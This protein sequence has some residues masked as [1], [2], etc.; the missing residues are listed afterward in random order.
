M[1]TTSSWSHADR[2]RATYEALEQHFG[3]S[4]GLYYETAPHR[5]GDRFAYDWPYSQALAGVLDMLALFPD[6][7]DV[8]RRAATRLAAHEAFWDPQ[9]RPPAYASAVVP[10]LGPSG[11][12]F[13]DDNAWDGLNLIRYVRFSGDG[14]WLE[15]ARL[16]FE[17]IVSGWDRDRRHPC[18][19]GVFWVR[20]RW[21]RDRGTVCNAPA[22]ILALH[23]DELSAGSQPRLFDWAKRMYQWTNRHLIAPNGLYW[24]KVLP[25]GRIDEAHWSYNQ[26]TMIGASVRFYRLTGD[27]AYRK[28]AE[29]I[30]DAS[31]RHYADVGFASQPPSFNAIFFRNLLQLS[32]ITGDPAHRAAMQTYADQCWNNSAV[33]DA[34]THLFKFDPVSGAAQLLDQG[35][36]VQVYACLARDP[37]SYKEL[38]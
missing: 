31:L 8:R 37:S 28:K 27:P 4:H 10:P 32:A 23:L 38:I 5:R 26:G 20:A 35:A 19:G 12:A 9:G 1:S 15:R 36:M 34:G 24:D 29:A 33:R 3:A 14:S 25:D 18:P 2:A 11:D 17:F 7:A 13:Y 30:A 21:N 16:V 22:A 6:D